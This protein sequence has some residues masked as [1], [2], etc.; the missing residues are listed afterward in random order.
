M[1]NVQGMRQMDDES[2]DLTVTSPPYD[3]LRTY[4]GYSFDFENVAKELYRVTKRCGVVMWVVNDATIDGKMNKIFIKRK[5]KKC[6]LMVSLTGKH[7]THC[8]VVALPLKDV[9]ICKAQKGE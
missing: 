2:V 3:N 7:P 8:G 5:C 6:H 9:K 1:D 4:N